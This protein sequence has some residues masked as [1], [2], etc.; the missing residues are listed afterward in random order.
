MIQDILE[1][2]R[3]TLEKNYKDF[4]VYTEAI[5]QGFER[6]CFF[7]KNL[8]TGRV[9]Q[10]GKFHLLDHPFVIQYFS[11]TK[12]KNEDYY[13]VSEELY[14]LLKFMENRRI[15]GSDISSQVVDGVLHFFVTYRIR[16]KESIEELDD[17]Q[18]LDIR[19]DLKNE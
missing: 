8:T 10:I 3:S 15:W 1:G 4:A 9:K 12:R 5:P 19:S 18:I 11:N 17:M 2:I 14:G 16:A 6:P 13:K 7:V